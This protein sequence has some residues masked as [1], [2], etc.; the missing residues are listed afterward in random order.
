MIIQKFGGAAMKDRRLRRLCIERIREGLAEHGT[1]AAVVSAIGRQ[2]SPYS[3]DRILSITP[4]FRPATAAWDLAAS[5]GELIAAAVLSAELAEA[6][7][8]NKVMHSRQSGILTA[9]AFSGAS[10]EQVETSSYEQAF[11]QFRC[12]IVP[13]FQGISEEGDYMTLGRGGSDLTAVVL[14]NALRASHVEF[15]KDVPGVM[16]ADPHEYEDARKL[17]TLTIDELFPYLETGRPVIQQRAADHAKKTATPLY[18]RGIA[19][20]EP[21]TWVMPAP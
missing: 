10:I 8:P 4:S 6:G 3:T 12:V 9:G 7:V 14:G 13:G 5:C 19:G 17:D 16:S 15:F 18:I 20:A 2:E 11:R 1:V 21:G